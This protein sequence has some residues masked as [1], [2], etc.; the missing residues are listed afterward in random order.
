MSE[1]ASYY[2]TKINV[3]TARPFVEKWHY[4]KS[5]P[6]CVYYFGLYRK[7]ELIGVAAYGKPAM[8]YQAKCY[9]CDIELRRLCLIDE[10]PKNA[11]SRF[12]SLTLKY[13][14]K[15]GVIAVL[16]LADP[17]HFHQGIIYKASNFEYLGEERGGGSRLIL[18]DGIEVHSRT[19]WAIYGTSGIK[20]LQKLLGADR[21]QGRNKKRKHVYR[22]VLN[23]PLITNKT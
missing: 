15:E 3:V 14:K 21:V 2:I 1:V 5:L 7:E 11:E 6:G 16:S 17:E 8:R 20:S 18:I 12:I 22:Y 10:T 9:G 4:S 19:A 13:L 23:T